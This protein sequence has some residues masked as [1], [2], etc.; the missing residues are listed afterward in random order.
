ME[1]R[2]NILGAHGRVRWDH[3]HAAPDLELWLSEHQPPQ[4]RGVLHY[5]PPSSGSA[6][7]LRTSWEGQSCQRR[8]VHNVFW[9]VHPNHLEG[10]L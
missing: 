1:T 10:L 4:H 7:Q 9:C 3:K 6:V 2:I 5:A 8:S